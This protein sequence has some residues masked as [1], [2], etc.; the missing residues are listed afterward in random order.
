MN[1]KDRIN[2]LASNY[3]KV[4]D[5]YR[6]DQNFNAN[7]FGYL[8]DRVLYIERRLENGDPNIDRLEKSINRQLN[9][10]N[11]SIET[12]QRELRKISQQS[13]D[14]YENMQSLKDIET[15]DSAQNDIISLLQTTME[16]LEE[17]LNTLKNNDSLTSK[18]LTVQLL[19]AFK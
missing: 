3:L 19:Q 16:N 11:E 9:F 2:K 18:Q 7:Q 17:T 4:S 13:K 5:E 6:Y 12:I 10:Y 15:N 1:T 8:K 14:M